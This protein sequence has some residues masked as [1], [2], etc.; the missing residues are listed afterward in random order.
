VSA[1]LDFGRLV[2]S[3][4]RADRVLVAAKRAQQRARGRERRSLEVEDRLGGICDNA[5]VE[6]E[7]ISAMFVQ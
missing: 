1:R 7:R 3:L 2:D 4:E 6:C 5:L